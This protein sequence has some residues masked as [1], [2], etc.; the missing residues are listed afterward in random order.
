MLIAALVTALFAAPV[1]AAPDAAAQKATNFRVL[2]FSKTAGFRHDSIPT[3]IATIQELGRENGFVAVPTEDATVFNDDNLSQYA[4]V[5][6]LST[7]GDVL[8]A[9]QQAAFERYVQGGGGFMGIHAAA[10]TEYEW[11]FYGELVGSYF[12]SHPAIQ[13]ATVKVADRVHPSTKH[14]DDRWV[15]TDEWYDYRANPRGDVHVLATLDET[16]YQNGS[17]GSDHPIAWCQDFQG[18]R[19]WYTGGGHTKES[20]GEVD[21]RKHLLGGLKW[22]A[23]DVAGDCGATVESNYEKVTLN[24][25]PGEPMGLTVLP[26]GRVLH[27]TRPGQ[28]RMHDPETQTNSVIAEFDLYTHDEEGLQSIAIDPNFAKNK[29]VYLYYSPPQ[30]TPVD[31]PSTPGVNE[32]NA[33]DEGTQADWDR[34]KGDIFLSRFKLNGNELDLASEQLI[35]KVPVD[36]GICCHVGGHIDFDGDGNLLL[37]T[38]DDT[39]PFASQGSTPID[40]RPERN[41]AYDAQRTAANTN[42][43]RGKLLRI[44]VNADGSYTSPKGNL[45]Q[46]DGEDK[47]RPEIYAMGM[48]NPFRMAVDRETDA[49]YLADYSPDA[50]QPDPARG[51]AGQGKWTVIREAGNYGWPYCATAELPYV[52]F[53]FAT[54][55]SGAPFDCAAP[56]NE[57][58]HNTGVRELPAVEQPDVWYSFGASTSFPELGTGGVGPMGGPAYDFD[59]NL[60]SETKFP[61]YWDGVPL[62]YEWTRDYVKEFRLDDDGNLLKINPFLPST[63][64]DNPMDMEFGPDGSLY[65]LEYGDGFFS[66]NPDAQL[67]RID[68]VKGKRRPIAQASA[69]PTSGQAPLAVQFSSDGSSDPDPGDSI[70]F[71]WDFQGDGTVD[72]TD[73]NP[74][75]TYTQNGVYEAGLTVTDSSGKTAVDTETITVGNTAPTVTIEAPV[76][77]GFFEF[78]DQVAFSVSAE[79]PEDTTIDCANMEVSFIL[80][81][82]E[83]GHPLST[84]TGCE[85][86]I[87][88]VSDGGHGDDADLFGVI[89]ATYTDMGAGGVPALSGTDEVILQPKRKQAEHFTTNQ[90][91]Q[92]ETTGDTQGGGLNI[93]FIDHG[94]HVSFQ[95]MNL[96]NITSLNY[97]VAS[98]GTGGRVEIHVDSPDG[99]VISTS[100]QIPV[101]GGWQTYTDVS[102]PVTDPGGTHELFF[103]FV[104]NP[105]DSGLFNIN[106]IDFVGQGVSVE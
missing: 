57:S 94:D 84:A 101:T 49:V 91:V 32:G 59:K 63:V 92:T 104:N 16:T 42:D 55:E 99:P 37:S 25:E 22:A 75:F 45:F 73:A 29:W 71:E 74:T 85:G 83:H 81:H 43:L 46:G 96:Q 2:V 79:D 69:T 95:P 54:G 93:G 87:Q 40:E 51:P 80:G 35:L 97:R 100:P 78:G 5:I 65:V 60:R 4:A 76:D 90:G 10:D 58:P 14:L 36:R 7:T 24:D 52:D 47:T 21:F 62:F 98:A 13:Q 68:Y 64:F 103:V 34:F 12:Q 27:T 23:G 70:R 19:S 102:A 8:N 26:D 28:V 17:M 67:A 82:D 18:G 77:G 50:G 9:D 6:F 66:E 11:P 33:P 38:G 56:V 39:N 15:R 44:H 53:D 89:S 1:D 106:W 31:D 48:R 72:S 61:E 20:Y 86:V 3:G 105:G 41:P 88:T 30:D